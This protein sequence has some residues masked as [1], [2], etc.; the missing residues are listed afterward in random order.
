MLVIIGSSK[1]NTVEQIH[2]YE[3]IGT[4]SQTD[5]QKIRIIG[6]SL[7]IGYAGTLMFGCYSLRYVP[8]SRTV[9]HT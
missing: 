1:T 2:L 8:A 9:D 3:L 5:M 4:A 7:I 6:V